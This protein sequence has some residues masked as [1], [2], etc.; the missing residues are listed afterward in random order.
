M[1]PAR[2][3]RRETKA[4]RPANWGIAHWIFP[5]FVVAVAPASA[6]QPSQNFAIPKLDSREVPVPLPPATYLQ[7]LKMTPEELALVDVARMNLLFAAALPGSEDLDI[8]AGLKA[9]DEMAVYVQKRT[10]ELRPKF[11]ANPEKFRNSEAFF[12]MTVLVT[13]LQKEK[14]LVYDPKFSIRPGE[15]YDKA[16]QAEMVKSSKN[17]FIN[18]LLSGKHLGTCSSM[19]VLWTAIGRRLGYPLSLV[20]AKKHLFVRWDDKNDRFNVEASQGVMASP[21]DEEYKTWPFPLTDEEIDKGPYLKN[22]T[23]AEEMADAMNARFWQLMHYQRYDEALGLAIKLRQMLPQADKYLALADAA[24][25]LLSP[26]SIPGPPADPTPVIPNPAAKIAASM[27]APRVSGFSSLPKE[28]TDRLPLQV[29]SV[30]GIPQPVNS[31]PGM[32]DEVARSLSPEVRA[33]M[34]VNQR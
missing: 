12:K 19:P 15:G 25:P 17:I 7:L 3:S 33:I 28:V 20:H 2:K 27:E 21:P 5:L 23:P 32:P 31:I 26:S 10:E 4:N 22:L 18:G 11:L 6:Q 24:A 29:R 34:Q 13:V 30:M 14:G 9:I 16:A 8:E 1:C